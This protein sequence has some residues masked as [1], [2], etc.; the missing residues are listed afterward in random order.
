MTFESFFQHTIDDQAL[1]FIERILVD[2]IPKLCFEKN[3]AK[4]FS[5][6]EIAFPR[7]ASQLFRG[8][9]IA[10]FRV[11]GNNPGAR[12]QSEKTGYRN[13]FAYCLR[14]IP[15]KP[16]TSRL[17]GIKSATSIPNLRA[18]EER[19][20]CGLRYSS[21]ITDDFTT[22]LIFAARLIKSIVCQ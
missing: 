13:A 1:T 16:S 21:S 10:V 9:C 17:T 11:D 22:S 4:V 7:Q 5:A 12:L 3:M 6:L 19:T 15:T 20:S 18:I 14:A 8:R 2:F